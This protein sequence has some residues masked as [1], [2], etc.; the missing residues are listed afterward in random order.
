MACWG[1][2]SHP[3]YLLRGSGFVPCA[4]CAIYAGILI[5]C[6]SCCNICYVN[7]SI[8]SPSTLDVWNMLSICV[9]KEKCWDKWTRNQ[10]A[11][12]L[13]TLEYQEHTCV[14]MPCCTRS[15]PC[16]SSWVQV[17]LAI[18]LCV[19]AIGVAKCTDLPWAWRWLYLFGRGVVPRWCGCCPYMVGGVVPR[20]WGVV[21][22]WWWRCP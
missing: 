3:L 7:N 17:A 18:A 20:W 8:P 1:H 9:R 12:L 11:T 10:E 21:P 16:A 2:P 4:Q 13:W 22:R 19:F 15:V 14:P 6:A 5:D